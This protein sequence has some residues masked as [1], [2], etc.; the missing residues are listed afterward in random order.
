[1]TTPTYITTP[2]YYVNGDP[3]IGH[4]YTTVVADFL[5]R[6]HRLAGDDTFF[7]TGT[8]EHGEKIFQAAQTAGM[9]TGAYVDSVAAKFA[10]AWKTLLVTNDDFI[11]TTEARHT[12]IVRQV[13]QSV[14]DQGDIYYDEYEGAYC[15]G[16]ERF[17]TDRDLVD[18]KCPDHNA[19]PET[20]R[21][22]NYFFRMEKHREW[23]RQHIQQTPEF[24][25][26]EGYANEVLSIL[27]EPIGDLSISRPRQRVPWGI[28]LPWDDDHVTYVWFD[29]LLNYVSALGY[30]D[31]ERYTH[32]WESAR[33]LI[34][35]DILKTHAIFWPTMLR[36]MGAPIYAGLNVGGYLMGSDGQKMSKTLGN[37]VDPF[38]LAERYSPD[39]VR[40]YLIKDVPY[41]Q[42]S[43]VGEKAL[44]D[45]HNADLANDLGNLVSRVR[46]LLLRHTD[47]KL[48]VP[49]ATPT[50]D[51][52]IAQGTQ[53]KEKVTELITNL[54]F[55]SALEEV[56]QFV[57]RL[58]R[59][60]NDE[61]PWK[62]A[63]AEDGAE[64][65]GT[66]L[67]TCVEGLR[68]VS[69]L[70][71]PALP[72]KVREL[73]HSLALPDGDLSAAGQWGLAPSGEQIPA[74]AQSLFPKAEVPEAEISAADDPSGGQDGG[75]N[76]APKASGKKKG[77]KK[78]DAE[79]AED[80]EQISID[81][82]FRVQMKVAQVTS[83][84]AVPKTDKLLKITLRVGEQERTV[85]SGIAQ[86]YD[87]ADLPG[88]RVVVVTNLKPAKL[89]GIIS[90]GMILAA[91][92]AD[93]NLALVEPDK[94]LPS[95]ATVR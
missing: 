88:R 28:G 25:R 42:D 70:L 35:K 26:P 49:V 19:V 84:E 63:K 67:Y 15:V 8:D 95:G 94:Q 4:A 91:E 77:P 86:F 36:A 21:E 75:A 17:L 62:L 46:A 24:I 18:G 72:M 51:E 82:F 3:H 78:P 27:S 31:G 39:A 93:G 60:F 61:E 55:W 58:N 14:Y 9:E 38:V 32:Y 53:L 48:P 43:S 66:V 33:H 12:Q 68:I 52:I 81:E 56:M 1:M 71:E 37:V 64:R 57:R 34:G 7:L 40:Y 90:E 23:L 22:G 10:D 13:L 69:I 83:A 74:E 29:A 30:P 73:R 89:R 65:L 2:L 79:P 92:D 54:K 59:Y 6:F 11:R 87:P 44:V 76:Q 50:E 16:C 41:G 20:R 5:A 85:V 47:G 80:V 45:R